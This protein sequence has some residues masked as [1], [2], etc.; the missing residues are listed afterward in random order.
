MFNLHFGLSWKERRH[1][2][3]RLLS[4][5]VLRDATVAFPTV[6]M[7]DFNFWLP[8]PPPRRLL[9]A[10]VDLGAAVGAS[11][12]TYPA[13]IPMLRLDRI[14]LGPGIVGRSARVHDSPMARQASDHR[15]LVAEVE[16][17]G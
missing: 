5:D 3:A 11:A 1:Q 9:T 15:P 8:G 12:P 7:G 2:T 10:L 13:R 14:Y 17:L 4:D 6:V 16:L